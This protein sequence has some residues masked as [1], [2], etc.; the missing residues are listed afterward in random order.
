MYF[1]ITSSLGLLSFSFQGFF[2]GFVIGVFIDFYRL[3]HFYKPIQTSQD[4]KL[5]L[6][7]HFAELLALTLQVGGAINGKQMTYIKNL[8][9][10][11]P[12]K[13]KEHSFL[14]NHFH[15]FLHSKNK[16]SLEEICLDIKQESQDQETY[17]FM[18]RHCYTLSSLEKQSYNF[19]KQFL[20]NLVQNLSLEDYIY[21]QKFQ[22]GAFHTK[23][24]YELLECLPNISD[25]EL[26]KQFRKLARFYHPDRYKESNEEEKKKMTDYFTLINEAYQRLKK[27]RNI[28]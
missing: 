8:F 19:Y 15:S 28:K 1:F 6:L 23:T 4:I 21:E 16:R 17:I 25:N 14:L 27:E 13:K 22:Q 2:I 10:K 3:F 5:H 20:N 18:Y 12:L 7:S 9:S 11:L 26:K 24:D